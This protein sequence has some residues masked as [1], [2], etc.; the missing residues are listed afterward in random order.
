MRVLQ[1]TQ[2][3]ATSQSTPFQKK[4]TYVHRVLL[5]NLGYLHA[6]RSGLYL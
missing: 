6:L 1:K 3:H 2:P 4:S 5:A